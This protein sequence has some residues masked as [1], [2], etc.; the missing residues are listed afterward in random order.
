M[1][2]L[3]FPKAKLS[4]QV[5]PSDTVNCMDGK[6]HRMT[7]YRANIRIAVATAKF[8]GGCCSF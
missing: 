8:L 3:A 2:V 1:D 5:P 4:Q 7:W 6:V